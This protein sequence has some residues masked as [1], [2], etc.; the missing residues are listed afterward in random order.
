[1]LKEIEWMVLSILHWRCGFLEWDAEELDSPD[2]SFNTPLEMQLGEYG[3]HVEPGKLFQY[4][5][6]DAEA[7][8]AAPAVL[9][10]ISIFQYSIGDAT[11]LSAAR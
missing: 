5:I 8:A 9:T 7:L 4:S 10:I 6:G 1:M 3:H 2:K 11:F